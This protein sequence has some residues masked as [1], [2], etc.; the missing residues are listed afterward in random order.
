MK[1]LYAL[2]EEVDELENEELKVKGV[3]ALVGVKLSL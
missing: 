1:L 2:L 3:V